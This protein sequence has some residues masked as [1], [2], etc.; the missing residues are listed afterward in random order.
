M[1]PANLVGAMSTEDLNR[2]Q[3]SVN[4]PIGEKIYDRNRKALFPI[5]GPLSDSKERFDSTPEQYPQA[6]HPRVDPVIAPYST[7]ALNSV[8]SFL[9]YMPRA[10]GEQSQHVLW[11]ELIQMKTRELELQI[12]EAR[13]KE[14]EAELELLRLREATR[15]REE[16]VPTS[17]TSDMNSLLGIENTLRH[18]PLQTTETASSNGPHQFPFSFDEIPPTA[19]E[20]NLH[21][22]TY[23]QAPSAIPLHLDS[24]SYETG[25]L[26]P[27]TPFDLEALM[28]SNDPNNMFSWLPDLPEYNQM[29]SGTDGVNPTDLFSTTGSM[30]TDHMGRP[31]NDSQASEYKPILDTPR[32]RRRSPSL[33]SNHSDGPTKKRFKKASEK[34]IVIE[35]HPTC[36]ICKKA[37]ARVLIRAPKSRIPD[38]ILINIACPNCVPVNQTP[39]IGEPV[40]SGS[41][42]G[43][44]ETR[45]RIRAALEVDDEEAKAVAR[46]T[47]C[48]VCQRIVGS[49][50]ISGGED[51]ESLGYMAE[52]I[53]VPCDSK[54]QR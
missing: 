15:A 22:V 25:T 53:C 31:R 28:Q 3:N 46:R 51:R 52:V 17:G 2:H 36:R 38:P 8:A 14:R 35:H 6:E 4:G 50:Q 30:Q 48:D 39:A 40:T 20:V 11:T 34:K 32:S 19:N 41:E 26:T 54:Y 18:A 16:V 49:G 10:S 37:L 5:L 27:M 43:T 42:F 44:V 23:P 45:K 9:E 13:Q 47:F 12:A 1:L 33:T 21:A 7:P 24:A 29:Y